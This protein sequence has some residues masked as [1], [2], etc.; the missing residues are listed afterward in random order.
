MAVPRPDNRSSKSRVV[1]SAISSGALL[2]L[3]LV[4]LSTFDGSSSSTTNRAELDAVDNFMK[5]LKD[6]PKDAKAAGAF[7]LGLDPSAGKA[8]ATV[9]EYE[10][11]MGY[12]R[13]VTFGQGFQLSRA[14]TRVGPH[15]MYMSSV[16]AP[17]QYWHTACNADCN[18]ILNASDALE[19]LYDTNNACVHYPPASTRGSIPSDEQEAQAIMGTSLGPSYQKN[20]GNLFLDGGLEE[21]GHT[22]PAAVADAIIDAVGIIISVMCASTKFTIMPLHVYGGI[23]L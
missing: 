5:N 6:D 21:R 16:L 8:T 9:G 4:A 7:S 1:V 23:F 12:V 13:A 18:Y 11:K 3:V 19:L 17:R 10:K 22:D 2:A 15:L 20:M 14:L